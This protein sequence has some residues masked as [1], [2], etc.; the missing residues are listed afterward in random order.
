V[1]ELVLYGYSKAAIRAEIDN[2]VVLCANC[3]RVKHH[4]AGP[5]PR[6]AVEQ[7]ESD[8]VL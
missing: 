6:T 7:P 2:C 3:H 4:E 5:R 8:R 1:N